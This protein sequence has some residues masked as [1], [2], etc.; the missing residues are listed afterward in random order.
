MEDVWVTDGCKRYTTA[1]YNAIDK[2]WYVADDMIEAFNFGMGA[3]I[4]LSLPVKY[5]KEI[6]GPN[7]Q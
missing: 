3:Q 5:W 2:E 4:K 1:W 7:E 6:K